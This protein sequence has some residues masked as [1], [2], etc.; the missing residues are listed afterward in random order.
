VLRFSTFATESN[1]D[2]VYVYDGA[3][4]SATQL[5][6][7][8]GDTVPGDQ[9]ASGSQMFVKLTSDGSTE[10]DGFTASFHCPGGAPAEVEGDEPC[11]GGVSLV[12]AGSLT[13][14]TVRARPGRLSAL[15]V[16]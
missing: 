9:A 3:G 1:F 16:P 5:G 14:G 12:N 10:G 7:F 2:H 11:N 4:D 6:D 13:A 15:S 8:H